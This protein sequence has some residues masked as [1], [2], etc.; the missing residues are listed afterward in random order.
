MPT[1]LVIIRHGN[2]FRK[3]D[4]L[5][6]VGARTDLPI[7]CEGEEQALRLGHHLKGLNIKP[8]RVFTSH[9]RRT[10]DTARLI[11][12]PMGCTKPSSPLDF[13]NEIDYGPDENQPEDKVIERLGESTLEK[14]DREA[15]MPEDWSPRPPEIILN[16]KNFLKQCVEEFENQ[17][18]FA[19]TSNGIAR[20]AL[21]LAKKDE[22][23]PLKLSTGAYGILEC[24]KGKNWRVTH[25]NIRP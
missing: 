6:R 4:I 5:T 20:F 3:G 22:N 17:T 15:V 23:V 9:L 19:V 18:V 7:T 1:R 10:I 8:A 24:E 25:W 11:C 13:L 14:W 2:T 21:A 16:W 12:L